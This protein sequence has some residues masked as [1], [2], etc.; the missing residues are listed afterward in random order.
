[1]RFYKKTYKKQVKL[2]S[3]FFI[4]LFS[5]NNL[6]AKGSERLNYIFERRQKDLMIEEIYKNNLIP[7]EEYDKFQNQLKTFFGMYSV[8]S[9]KSYYP[10]L[11]LINDS[12][13]IRKIYK[14]KLKNMTI[15]KNNSIIK[16]KPI[17]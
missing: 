6:M 14:S 8:S 17:L 16:N 2:F 15:N 4:I 3:S 1:M 9:H 10:D 5:I 11:M 13:S 12:R 7:H